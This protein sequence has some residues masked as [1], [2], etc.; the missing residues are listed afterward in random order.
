MPNI[1]ERW[2]HLQSFEYKL[3]KSRIEHYDQIMALTDDVSTIAQDYDLQ[4]ASILR[5]KDYAFGSGVT[6]YGFYPDNDMADA[7]FRLAEGNGNEL[8]YVFLLHEIHESDLVQNQN[9]PQPLAHE[10][11]Q[12]IYPW[13]RLLKER[14]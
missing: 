7:W 11:T 6:Q 1:P 8:D 3:L 12:A 4:V 14:N 2:Q 13:S 10:K 5:A 9:I